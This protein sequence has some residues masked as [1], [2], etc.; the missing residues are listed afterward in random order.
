M[1]ELDSRSL[2]KPVETFLELKD[3]SW[4]G[5]ASWYLDEDVLTLPLLRRHL[6]KV[7]WFIDI[8]TA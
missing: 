4:I 1:I 5:E 7:W 6:I 3:L 8:T 2:C